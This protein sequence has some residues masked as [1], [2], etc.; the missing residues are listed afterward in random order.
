MDS[1]NESTVSKSNDVQCCEAGGMGRLFIFKGV[2]LLA[3][4][5][6]FIPTTKI[7]WLMCFTLYG[8]VLRF[9]G[10][11]NRPHF[12]HRTVSVGASPRYDSHSPQKTHPPPAAPAVYGISAMIT[13]GGLSSVRIDAFVHTL[14]SSQLVDLLS[15]KPA[16]T[17]RQSRRGVGIRTSWLTVAC[18]MSKYL[19]QGHQRILGLLLLLYGQTGIVV[20]GDTVSR[21]RR[22]PYSFTNY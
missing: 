12:T 19:R 5:I 1:F 3:V 11:T 14:S 9:I 18:Y 13:L 2:T 20:W 6:P 17:C 22:P 21:Y 16:D 15:F 7:L 4:C 10:W 8:R